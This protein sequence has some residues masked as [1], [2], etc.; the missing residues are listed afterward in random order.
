MKKLFTLIIIAFLTLG[1]FSCAEEEV[2]PTNENGGQ[3]G[4]GA[5]ELENGF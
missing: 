2:L 5:G 3:N 1:A 4:V